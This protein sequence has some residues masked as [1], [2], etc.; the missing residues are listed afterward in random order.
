[1]IA[2]TESTNLFE[3]IKGQTNGEPWELFT[4]VGTGNSPNLNG[5]GTQ[6]FDIVGNQQFGQQVA[7]VLKTQEPSQILLTLSEQDPV[8]TRQGFAIG[9]ATTSIKLQKNIGQRIDPSDQFILN[10]TGNPTD[11]VATTGSANGIQAEF[12]Q[13]Y[14]SPGNTFRLNE[15]MA[16]GSA[17]ALSDYTLTVSAANATPAGSVPPITS[18]PIQ[19]TTALGDDVTYTFLNAAPEIFIKTVDKAFADVGEIITYTVKVDNPNN[20]A[21]NNVLVTDTV[22]TG[23]TYLGNLTVSEPYT[24]TDPQSGIVITTIGASSSATLSW[25]V[26]VNTMPPIS[27]P[28][29][30]FANITIPGGTSGITNVVTTKVNTAFVSV[31]KTVDK[32]Y[33]KLG[34]ILTYT[35][36]L[37]NAG[38]VPA[39]NVVITDAIPVGTTFVPGSVIGA[40]GTP[41]TLTLSNPIPAG[42]NAVVT[43]QVKVGD[44]IPDPNPIPNTPSVAYTYT[45]DP[46]NPNGASG[47]RNG[48]TVTTQ[49]NT[50]VITVSKGVDKP[51]AALGEILT[52]TLTLKNIGNVVADNVVITDAIPEGTAFVPGSVTGATG[53]PPVLTL[54]NPIPVGGS[55]V[56]TFQVKVGNSLPDINPIPN[57]ASTA[58]TFTV[59]PQNPNGETGGGT[60]NTVTTQV[61]APIVSTVKSVD[62]S[63][64]D[65][66]EVLTYTLTLKN[67][68]NVSADN[69]IITDAIPSGTTFLPGSVVGAAGVPP[70]LTLT[71]P[72]PAGGKAVI[73]FQV[74]VGNSIPVPNPI[75]NSASI[76]F[77]YTA[78][79]SNPDGETGGGTSNTVTTVVNHAEV[80]IIKSVDK[81]Y[82]KPDGDILTY[83]LNVVN[84]GNVTANNVTLVDAVPLGTT[85]VP[86]SVMGATGVPPTLTITNPIPAGGNA[87]VSFQVKVEGIP[88]VNPI[89]NFGVVTY[90]YTVD[91]ANPNDKTNTKRSN[92]V[93][94]QVSI[95]TLTAVKSVDKSTSYIGD[96]IT[97]QIAVKNTG[98]VPANN[99]VLK[100]PLPNGVSYIPG[101]L[102]VSVPY[103]G[104]LTSGIQFTNPIAPDQ[105]VTLSFKVKVD[106]IPNPN[107]VINQATIGFTYTVDPENPN[108]E[109]G[110][111][112]SNKVCTLVFRNNYAQEIS[113]IIESVAQEQAALAAIANAEGAKIQKLVAMGNASTQE[114][115]C[116]N[117]SATDMMDSI[118]MLENILLQKLS[119][120]ACQINGCK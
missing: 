33:A 96:I 24:G 7:Y 53:I 22:P 109:T 8:Q 83:T 67:D 106:S 47:N 45:V 18:L 29:P 64:A 84:T 44:S 62:K 77:T 87:I 120:F 111:V 31:L 99:A 13:V 28:I 74:M 114:L 70:T 116:L 101:T 1:M 57:T 34:E 119:I 56:V 110:I 93:T 71:N 80:N 52:Y 104:S 66:G 38:N 10:I 85:F 25:Q 5:V 117:Q 105:T 73:T 79:P 68:G 92:T 95:A 41:P 15:G 27:N 11:Q 43:F 32:V 37:G 113:D 39:N 16:F 20:F 69:V 72:I 89:P 90:S 23:T 60:S 42:G 40:T 61:N 2:D 50:A 115:L 26:Q 3:S 112:T 78:N 21:V 48:N 76:R 46:S 19:F 88:P 63:Y 12:A 94:T 98:N 54:L 81:A 49:V 91:P 86:G 6:T 97:Y 102:V 14:V 118:K 108:G 51:Y 17:S 103:S 4:V 55:A 82:A 65:T 9:F 58:Y 107:P 30:N 36:A 100:D 35:L 59:D 75:S